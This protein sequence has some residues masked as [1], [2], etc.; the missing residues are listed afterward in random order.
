MSKTNNLGSKDI[1]ILFRNINYKSE[2]T[3][4]KAD[5]VRYV[6]VIQM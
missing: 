4:K 5:V 6:E 2:M 1:S 3:G